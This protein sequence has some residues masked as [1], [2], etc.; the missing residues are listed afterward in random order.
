[1][2]NAYIHTLAIVKIVAVAVDVV[3]TVAVVC[4]SLAGG[5]AY[6]GA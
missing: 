2:D 6:C 1:L 3:V 4:L 5:L